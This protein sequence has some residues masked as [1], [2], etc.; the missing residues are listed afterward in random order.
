MNPDPSALLP[1]TAAEFQIL[2]SL[3]GGERHGYAIM[4]DAAFSTRGKLRLGPGTLYRS[5]KNLLAN[6]LIEE[7]GERPDPS[8]D[9]ERRRYYRLTALGYR[10][11]AAEAARL[12]DLVTLAHSR[13]G[14]GSGRGESSPQGAE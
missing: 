9:D 12:A 3:A 8:L 4:Q 2:L 5:I 6:G 7:R 11:A 10:A 13:L 14:L 1:L